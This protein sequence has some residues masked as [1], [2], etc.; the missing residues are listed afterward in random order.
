MPTKTLALVA[1]LVACANPRLA[2]AQFNG[3][4]QPEAPA[5]WQPYALDLVDESGAVLP[6]YQHRGRTYVLGAYGQRYLVRVRNDSGRRAEVVVSVD[7]R[8]VIEGRP[9]S[10]EKR[11]YL[12]EPRGEVLID[13][14]R[15]SQASVAAFRFASV[16]RSYA[17]RMGDARDVG[18][19]GVAVFPERPPRRMTTPPFRPDRFL[20][21]G[22]PPEARRDAAPGASSEAPEAMPPAG[23]PGAATPAPRAFGGAPAPRPGLGTE[24][25]E[26]HESSVRQVWFERASPRPEAVLTVRYDDREGLVALG[27]DVDGRRWAGS[28]NAWLRETAE[29]FR[30]SPGFSE[31]PPGWSS[32]W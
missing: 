26:E 23:A 24:F 8:D 27:I 31:P 13:G 6:T 1:A 29:P 22:R 12:V 10:W 2:A 11:G 18:V 20:D 5:R 25:G 7:G 3:P 15:L 16:D 21:E 19:I 14:F 28:E 32:R 17:A 4:T 30:R 9:A